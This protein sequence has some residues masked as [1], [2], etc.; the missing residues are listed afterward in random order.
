M[1]ETKL[2]KCCGRELP[3]SQFNK[4]SK[5]SDGLQAYCKDCQKQKNQ[6]SINKRKLE[7]INSELAKYTPRELIN[8]LHRR[9]YKGTLTYEQQIKL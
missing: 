1:M 8:E 3:I 7:V 9:G 5:N 2:C 6:L 4:H